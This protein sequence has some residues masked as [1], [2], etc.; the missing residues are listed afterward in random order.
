MNTSISGIMQVGGL[1]PATAKAV[2]CGGWQ[3]T[4]DFDADISQLLSYARA[5]NPGLEAAFQHWK[6]ALERVPQATTLP[7]PR[8]SFSGYLSEVETRT[9]PMQARIGL[10]QPFPWFG[11][12]EL[13]GSVAFEVSEAA[14]EMLEAARLGSS[15]GSTPQSKVP[16]SGGCSPVVKPQS[17]IGN[18]DR[19]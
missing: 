8:L 6:A 2:A 19:E 13:A 9:G 4:T 11:E 18:V 12:L 15:V 5:T 16:G 3:C 14:R 7:E 17:K 1:T 10:A